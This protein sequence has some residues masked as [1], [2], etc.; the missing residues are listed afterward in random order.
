M[1]T[2]A[3]AALFAL[4][5]SAA[6]AQSIA[7]TVAGHGEVTYFDLM[8][9][10]I[11]DLTLSEEGATGHLPE[12]IEHIDGPDSTGETPEQV[13]ISTVSVETVTSGGEDMTVAPVR[14]AVA[15]EPIT[16]TKTISRYCVMP[17]SMP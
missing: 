14:P 16:E 10:V 7:D 3:L 4:A 1:K 5:S 2:L 11:P 12:G 6:F 17:S 8:K 9:Q 15:A 13:E